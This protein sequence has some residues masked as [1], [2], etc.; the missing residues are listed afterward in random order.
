MDH[1][2]HR[3]EIA[4]GFEK[5]SQETRRNYGKAR[6]EQSNITGI[7]LFGFEDSAHGNPM[8]KCFS[9]LPSEF[10]DL[11]RFVPV[12]LGNPTFV[13][14]ESVQFLLYNLGYL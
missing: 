13:T 3:P 4:R 14:E 8:L 7:A 2:P 5:M 6:F 12:I 1:T 10:D 11:E 9:I